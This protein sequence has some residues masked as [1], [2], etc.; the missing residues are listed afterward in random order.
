[1]KRTVLGHLQKF[2][3]MVRTVTEYERDEVMHE[4]GSYKNM[5]NYFIATE[6]EHIEDKATL[7]QLETASSTVTR[8]KL[9]EL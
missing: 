9:E 2:S 8:D 6:I 3:H 5:C 4:T 1:M 7:G